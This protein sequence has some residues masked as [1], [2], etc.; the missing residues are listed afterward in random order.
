[1]SV[2]FELS[3]GADISFTPYKTRLGCLQ[4]PQNYDLINTLFILHN[5]REFLTR[6]VTKVFMEDHFPSI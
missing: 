4:M 5:D 3:L 2:I 1:M 6:C